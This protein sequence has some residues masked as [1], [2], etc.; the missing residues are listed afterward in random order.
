M[1]QMDDETADVTGSRLPALF[2]AEEASV[3]LLIA[4]ENLFGLLVQ[5]DK[6]QRVADL[7]EI[8]ES[9]KA[10]DDQIAGL[11]HAEL[12]PKER[13]M[14]SQIEQ[15]R[16]P[17]RD[18][19][20]KLIPLALADD[21]AGVRPLIPAWR[22]GGDKVHALLEKLVDEIKADADVESAQAH[23]S[24]VDARAVALGATAL[25]LLLGVA[26]AL[27][28]VQKIV[29]S[30]QRVGDVARLMAQEDLPSLVSVAQALA[31]GDLTQDAS[32]HVQRVQVS[33]NDEIG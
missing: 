19:E 29:S 10:F 31:Q 13:Q 1:S 30:V 3:D 5:R 32:I 28:L 27:F 26:I 9:V 7:A 11:K 2:A 22:D 6:A 8:K 4:R 25:A 15:Q 24:Y 12:T 18:A 21:E 20:T 16:A 14:V 17:M 23:E 33:S